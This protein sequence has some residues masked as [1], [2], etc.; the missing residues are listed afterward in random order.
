MET[1]NIMTIGGVDFYEE[2]YIVYINLEAAARGLGFTTVAASGNEVVR[3]NTVHKYLSDYGV[4]RSCNGSY[5]ERCPDFIPENIFYRLAMKAKNEKAEAFQA[6]VADEVIPTI[7]RT[8]SYSVGKENLPTQPI[9]EFTPEQQ[10]YIDSKFEAQE[11]FFR[12]EMKKDRE[13]MKDELNL[14]LVN[15][16]AEL[17]NQNPKEI[18]T[19][20]RKITVGLWER[21]DKYVNGAE[22]AWKNS[23]YALMDRIVPTTVFPT[24]N[25]LFKYI[26][27]YMNKHYGI[28]WSQEIKDYR[29]K[30]HM[31]FNPKTFD[32][33]YDKEMYQSIFESI[34]K[35]LVARYGEEERYPQL[36]EPSQNKQEFVQITLENNPEEKNENSDN[37]SVHSKKK[38]KYHFAMNATPQEIIKPLATIHNDNSPYGLRTFRMIY[39]HMDLNDHLKVNWDNLSARYKKKYGTKCSIT[40]TMLINESKVTKDKFKRAV[41][42]LIT[43][44]ESENKSEE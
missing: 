6:W 41:R 11:K 19:A 26:Y 9:P 1:S 16:M 17:K 42:E 4:A 12:K 40:R 32:I 39:K 8:G 18:E 25:V 43:Q 35:D 14:F 23:M 36:S 2:N 20:S 5:R 44:E 24:K 28:C 3:W 37:T 7:R 33:V 21:H 22:K 29:E 30:Y 10:A 34:L 31:N 38:C 15:F 27:Q 13:A